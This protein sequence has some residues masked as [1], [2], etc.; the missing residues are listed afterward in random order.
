MNTA[1]STESTIAEVD[2]DAL[3]PRGVLSRYFFTPERPE[4]LA[5][6]RILYCVW[7]LVYYAGFVDFRGWSR[8][9]EA[10]YRPVALHSFLPP[11]PGDHIVGPLQ[12]LWWTLLLL[13]A[14]GFLTRFSLGFA[15]GLSLY[16][17]GLSTSFGKISHSEPMVIFG[18]GI[19]AFSR[20]GDVW[21]VD[22]WLRRRRGIDTT[23]VLSG[24]YRWPIRTVW[25]VMAMVFFQA[26]LNKLIKAGPGWAAPDSFGPQM[27]Q[28]FYTN[29]PPLQI[30]LKLAWVTPFLWVAGISSLAGEVLFPLA[31][32]WRKA[33][34]ILPAMMFTMQ[35][36]IAFLLG[37]YFWQYM[38]AYVF[39]VPW[40]LI[41]WGRWGILKKSTGRTPAV[42]P[43]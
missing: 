35:L 13:G 34:L 26:G 43:A 27:L 31:L 18:L 9:T 14:A 33:R 16:L 1:A 2:H 25:V 10:L 23:P 41:F 15:C 6:C 19:L 36:N 42:A 4:P 24:E 30:G 12:Y 28:H 37:V 17:L 32:V 7:L 39:W 22:A 29:S 21:S 5:V 11:P 38:A 3:R 20:C 8:V 40:P